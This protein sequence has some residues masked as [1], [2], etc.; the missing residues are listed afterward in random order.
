MCVEVGY[1]YSAYIKLLLEEEFKGVNILRKYS[2]DV[3]FYLSRNYLYNITI[4]L[5][6]V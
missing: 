6:M 3:I 2:V 1:A 5:S 4:I